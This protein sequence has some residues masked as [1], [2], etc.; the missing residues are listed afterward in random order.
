M[1]GLHSPLHRLAGSAFSVF[2]EAVMR[3]L[4][5]GVELFADPVGELAKLA[6]HPHAGGARDPFRGARFGA[7]ATG[8]AGRELAT[9]MGLVIEPDGAPDA[10]TE[11]VWWIPDNDVSRSSIR[12]VASGVP[13]PSSARAEP[14]ALVPRAAQRG[15]V[16][17]LDNQPKRTSS[18][19]WRSS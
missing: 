11:C 18:S 7:R 12:P 9:M 17:T 3:T 5:R 1:V 2:E 19:R 4:A 14:S 13:G 8:P 16:S 15:G 10:S 6:R